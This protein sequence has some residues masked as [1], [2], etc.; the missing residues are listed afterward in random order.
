M[1]GQKEIVANYI[2]QPYL[3][4]LAIDKNLSLSLKLKIGQKWLTYDCMG[5]N[6]FIAIYEEFKFFKGN[7]K[8]NRFRKRISFQKFFDFPFSGLYNLSDKKQLDSH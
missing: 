4:E 2:F 1:F 8:F 3:Q 7:T 5:N 6:S